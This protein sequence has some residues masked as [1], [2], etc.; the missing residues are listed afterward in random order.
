M[1]LASLAHSHQ[2]SLLAAVHPL[3]PHAGLGAVDQSLPYPAG[4][5]SG[6]MAEPLSNGSAGESLLQA[7]LYILSFLVRR[8]PAPGP[9][10]YGHQWTVW[11]SW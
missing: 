10:G 8:T 1:V 9:G 3:V 4:Q 7:V 11:W 6:G 2:S 5:A